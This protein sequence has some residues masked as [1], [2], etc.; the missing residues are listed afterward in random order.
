MLGSRPL[1][2][3]VLFPCFV[4]VSLHSHP[5]S[6]SWASSLVFQALIKSS[7]IHI[8]RFNPPLYVCLCTSIYLRCLSLRLSNWVIFPLDYSCIS[9]NYFSKCVMFSIWM[10]FK[11]NQ[12]PNSNGKYSK[13]PIDQFL[14]Y[15][16]KE[17]TPPYNARSLFLLVIGHI[18]WFV[19]VCFL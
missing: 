9:Q 16:V 14:T 8:Y 4:C 12:Q 13:N 2:A 15:E 1:A 11:T 6:D 10:V 19:F 18:D 17:Q 7:I 5:D 3:S